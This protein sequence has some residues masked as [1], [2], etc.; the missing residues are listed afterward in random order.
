[1]YTIRACVL[2]TMC[3]Q[4]NP[5]LVNVVGNEGSTVFTKKDRQPTPGGRDR[6]GNFVRK[7]TG[8]AGDEG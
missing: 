3:N 6:G 4:R 5:R 8:G 7:C 2:C 1:M